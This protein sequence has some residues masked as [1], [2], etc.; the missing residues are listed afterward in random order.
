[1][2]VFRLELEIDSEVYPELHAVL[3]AVGSSASCGERLRQLAASG[4]V[5]ETVRVHGVGLRPGARSGARVAERRAPRPSG[6]TDFVDLAL[7][8]VPA[9]APEPDDARDAGMHGIDL[10]VPTQP[11]PMLLDVVHPS[12]RAN[13]FAEPP[14]EEPSVIAH[15]PVVRSRLLRMKEKGLFRNG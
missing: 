15:K 4:L 13:D 3:T 7:D 5:W 8:A 2:A 12:P 14:A 10:D 6:R 9:A 11:I 1:M